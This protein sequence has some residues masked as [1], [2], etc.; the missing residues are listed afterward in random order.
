MSLI[1]QQYVSNRGNR[2]Q[3]GVPDI[4]RLPA[5][6]ST[7]SPVEIAFLPAEILSVPADNFI[8]RIMPTTAHASCCKQPGE[9]GF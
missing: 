3:T 7:I 1:H 8:L 9:R 6:A 5:V 4:L 2:E